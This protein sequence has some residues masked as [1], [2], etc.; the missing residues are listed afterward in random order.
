MGAWESGY[1]VRGS[2]YE[3]K[4]KAPCWKIGLT[5]SSQRT[6]RRAIYI[7]D[8]GFLGVLGGL[9]RLKGAGVRKDLFFVLEFGILDKTRA[10]ARTRDRSRV[11]PITDY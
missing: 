6:Q 5:Q 1:E 9:E 7:K 10:R 11:L 3:G 8:S 2:R 4:L